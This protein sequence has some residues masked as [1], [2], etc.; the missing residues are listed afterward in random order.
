MKMWVFF[1]IFELQPLSPP[2]SR[3]PGRMAEKMV[4]KGCNPAYKLSRF[5]DR[6]CWCQMNKFNT[7]YKQYENL[8]VVCQ[9]RTFKIKF[10][11]K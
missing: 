5:A 4:V 3:F 11:Q 10:Q 2:P 1:Y 8:N 6:L 9:H 7:T